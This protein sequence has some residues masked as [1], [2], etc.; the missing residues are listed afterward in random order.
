MAV[1]ASIKAGE[2]LR[3][4]ALEAEASAQKRSPGL[5]IVLIDRGGGHV[6]AYEPPQPMP[7]LDVAPVPEAQPAI[8]SDAE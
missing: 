3:I 4:G 6:V 1:V 8:P 5:S 2:Q 7:L